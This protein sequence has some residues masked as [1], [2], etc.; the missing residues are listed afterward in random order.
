MILS[1]VMLLHPKAA[2]SIMI[3]AWALKSHWAMLGDDLEGE[4]LSKF[5]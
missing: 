4:I 5:K 3:D 2:D 1:A